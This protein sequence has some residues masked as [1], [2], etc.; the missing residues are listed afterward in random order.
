MA[1]IK[2]FGNAMSMRQLWTLAVHQ[3]ATRE[4]IV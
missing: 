1:V 4:E 3:N 2:M